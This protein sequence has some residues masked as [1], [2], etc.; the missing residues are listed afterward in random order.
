MADNYVLDVYR[1][2]EDPLLTLVVSAAL[3]VDTVLH[4]GSGEQR[5]R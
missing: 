4:Q 5:S 2:L 3:V 1:Q